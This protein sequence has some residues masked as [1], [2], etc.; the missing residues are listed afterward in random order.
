MR[1]WLPL[2]L[3]CFLVTG[4]ATTSTKGVVEIGPDTY[5][6]GGLG[7]FTD[8]SGSAVKA[9]LYEQAAEFCKSK[10]RVMVPINST[11]HDSDFAQYASAEI[12]FLALLPDDS[13]VKNTH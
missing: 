10:G 9:R 12:Q 4:C 2:L 6:I 13:R 5:M 7:K 11:A 1:L 8:F 3:A